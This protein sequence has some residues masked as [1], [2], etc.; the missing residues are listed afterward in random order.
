MLMID[1]DP[2]MQIDIVNLQNVILYD[3]QISI[4]ICKM[5]HADVQNKNIKYFKKYYNM[6]YSKAYIMYDRTG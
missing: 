5:Q 3:K 1:F 6:K 4:N 2:L